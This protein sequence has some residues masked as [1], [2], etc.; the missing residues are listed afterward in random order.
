MC[1]ENLG[2]HF[3]GAPSSQSLIHLR[4]WPLF[5]MAL[6]SNR[7][8]LCFVFISVL[9]TLKCPPHHCQLDWRRLHC[10]RNASVHSVH[11]GVIKR[12]I[13]V[14]WS[15][16]IL[17]PSTKWNLERV[18]NWAAK[19]WWTPDKARCGVLE[20]RTSTGRC[21]RYGSRQQRAMGELEKTF[22]LGRGLS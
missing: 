1:Q 12:P 17:S 11:V 13:A 2:F 15:S 9:W 10:L 7:T 8:E 22:G 3:L 4:L 6:P 18:R 16:Y 21:C 20:Q 19:H 14:G 5:L